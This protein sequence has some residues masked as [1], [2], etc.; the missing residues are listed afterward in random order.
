MGLHT[1]VKVPLGSPLPARE[2]FPFNVFVQMQ[3]AIAQAITANLIILPFGL[4]TVPK[5]EF[6]LSC[7][8]VSRTGTPADLPL[9]GKGEAPGHCRASALPRLGL[10]QELWESSWFSCCE[11]KLASKDLPQISFLLSPSF[12]SILVNH[13]FKCIR[14]TPERLRPLPHRHELF[15]FFEE[16]LKI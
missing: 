13:T 15:V 12:D 10:L 8:N 4:R 6:W 7:C 14:L 9:P 16:E 11:K 2:P 3:A 5:E 1:A